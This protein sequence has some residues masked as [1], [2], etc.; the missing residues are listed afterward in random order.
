MEKIRSMRALQ[1]GTAAKKH[2]IQSDK[3]VAEVSKRASIWE[4][5]SEKHEQLAA[6]LLEEQADG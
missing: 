5:I 4:R 3:N 1:R 6:C 2:L